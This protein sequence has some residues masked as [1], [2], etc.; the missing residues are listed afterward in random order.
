MV[1]HAVCVLERG[2]LALGIPDAEVSIHAGRDCTFMREPVELAR[3][4]A[5]DADEVLDL[6]AAVCYALE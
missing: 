6:D 5:S 3:V 1:Q 2:H 4:G